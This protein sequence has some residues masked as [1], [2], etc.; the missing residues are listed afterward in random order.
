M[1]RVGPNL[2]KNQVF[3]IYHFFFNIII[4]F[5]SSETVLLLYIK[6]RVSLLC[7]LGCRSLNSC[8]FMKLRRS[9]PFLKASRFFANRT[10]RL[11]ARPVAD[12]QLLE[13]S[14]C[15]DSDDTPMALRPARCRSCPDLGRPGLDHISVWE[16]SA[17]GSVRVCGW[18]SWSR[19]PPRTPPREPQRS[20]SLLGARVPGNLK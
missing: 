10:R 5:K 2:P 11:I 20:G 4:C 9:P 13:E 7:G 17:G 14:N 6:M 12:P 8:G 1:S 18:G 19:G 16:M 3:R 15:V